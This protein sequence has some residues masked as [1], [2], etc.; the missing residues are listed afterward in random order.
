MLNLQGDHELVLP[1][2]RRTVR[3]NYPQPILDHQP[4]EVIMINI[5]VMIE[6]YSLLQNFED[7]Q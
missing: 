1:S 5:M 6:I 4:G 7:P 3:Y 2:K